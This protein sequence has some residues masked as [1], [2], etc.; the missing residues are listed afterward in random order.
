MMLLP[1]AIVGEMGAK[2][3]L[4]GVDNGFATFNHVRV[5]RENLLNR[6][7][8]VTADGKY[9]TPFKVPIFEF[10]HPHFI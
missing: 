3:G 6:T 8:D 9:V 2:S 1:G 10:K 5:P 7:G 4:N